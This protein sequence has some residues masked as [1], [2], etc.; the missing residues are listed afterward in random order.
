MKRA[1]PI[2]SAVSRNDLLKGR[3]RT[4]RLEPE[5]QMFVM[6]TVRFG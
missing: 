4:N 5:F 2:A 3:P 6:S 1:G